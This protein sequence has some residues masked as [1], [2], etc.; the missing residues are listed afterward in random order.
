MLIGADQKEGVDK[1]PTKDQYDRAIGSI[2]AN[3]KKAKELYHFNG[4]HS[5]I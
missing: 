1:V 5:R 3:S 4:Y 2:T